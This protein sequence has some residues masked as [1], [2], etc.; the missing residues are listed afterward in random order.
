MSTAKDCKLTLSRR[1]G[2]GE[3]VP[4]FHAVDYRGYLTGIAVPRS[5]GTAVT[6]FFG[7]PSISRS[8]YVR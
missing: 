7:E 2:R 5:T 4:E 6:E 1:L 3:S 8:E